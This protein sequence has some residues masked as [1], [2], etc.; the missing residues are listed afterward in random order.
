MNLIIMP[1]IDVNIVS[2]LIHKHTF[3]ENQEKGSFSCSFFITSLISAQIKINLAFNM[4][5]I[6]NTVITTYFQSTSAQS[7]THSIF[8]FIIRNQP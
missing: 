5:T 2:I 8:C 3:F 7:I 6:R 1:K 4:I